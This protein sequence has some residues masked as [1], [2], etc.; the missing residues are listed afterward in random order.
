M[1]SDEA[2]KTLTDRV[3]ERQSAIIRKLA[4]EGPG[5][6]VGRCAD[7]VL[8]DYTNC[9]N[10]FIYAYKEDRIRRIMKLYK[11]DEKQA[12]DKIRKTDRDRKNYYEAR[13]KRQWG[14][15]DANSMMFNASLL[16]IDGVV[17]ALEAIYRKWEI[18]E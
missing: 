18:R 9:I 4:D 2:G 8:G 11:L 12:A 10:T 5:I 6:F 14:G 17:D 1:N 3:Y 7:Y 15:I 16:G 13:T